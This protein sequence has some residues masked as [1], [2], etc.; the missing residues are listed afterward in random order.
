MRSERV[1]RVGVSNLRGLD[2]IEEDGKLRDKKTIIGSWGAKCIESLFV[3]DS[4][5]CRTKDT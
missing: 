2:Y 3:R 1:R 5:G 4:V